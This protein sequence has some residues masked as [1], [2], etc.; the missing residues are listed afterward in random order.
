MATALMIA[1]AGMKFIGSQREAAGI[2]AAGKAQLAQAEYRAKQG[3]QIAGQ[4]RASSQRAAIEDRRKGRLAQSRAT[5]LAAAGG[6]T[7]GDVSGI[8]GDL[9]AES[10]Y[11]ALTSLFE[12]DDRAQ[13][14]ESQANLDMYDG[15][16][17]YRAAKYSAKTTKMK[18][19]GD[20]II[21]GSS[22]YQKYAPSSE[23][24]ANGDSFRTR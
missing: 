24:W 14:L 4:E 8:I 5:A 3:R 20:L 2:K 7:V 15:E 19:Y 21:G 1:S 10:E 18:G 12:G 13:Q 9:G 23:T 16:S 6:G 22:L 11:S 17:A